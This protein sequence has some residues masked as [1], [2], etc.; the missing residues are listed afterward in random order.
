M[1]VVAKGRRG[2]KEF[3]RICRVANCS[4]RQASCRGSRFPTKLSLAFPPPSLLPLPYSTPR[5][6]HRRRLL[7]LLFF[8]ILIKW[9]AL[10][11][12]RWAPAADVTIKGDL[13]ALPQSHTPDPDRLI[14]HNGFCISNNCSTVPPPPPLAIDLE[15]RNLST[16][17][18]STIF[19]FILNIPAAAAVMSPSPSAGLYNRW[20]N[21]LCSLLLGIVESRQ[22]W[23]WW[24]Y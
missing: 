2:G 10:L 3:S 8:S 24:W 11:A 9:L 21:P 4:Q 15:N 19:I 18:H 7:L 13:L 22:W 12:A 6:Y 1:C 20:Y 5:H 23:R 17:R 14:T 16:R